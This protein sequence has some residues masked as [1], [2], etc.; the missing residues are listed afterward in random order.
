[1]GYAQLL[2]LLRITES[3]LGK[4]SLMLTRIKRLAWGWDHHLAT[5]AAIVIVAL[6]IKRQTLG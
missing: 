6:N 4:P 3:N 1:M 5:A 2:Y